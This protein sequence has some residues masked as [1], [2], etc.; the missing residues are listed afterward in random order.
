MSLMVACFCLALQSAP[1]TNPSA[2]SLAL[3]LLTRS[4]VPTLSSTQ[5]GTPH[6]QPIR[7]ASTAKVLGESEDPVGGHGLDIALRGVD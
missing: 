6:G 5:A 2:L 1:T 4:A 7:P 3:S